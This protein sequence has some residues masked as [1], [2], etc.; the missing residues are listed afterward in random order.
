M[1][2]SDL[3]PHTQA[4]LISA[5]ND[6]APVTGLTHQHYRYPARF[7][8]TFV[9]AAI[10][11]FTDPGDVVLDP[12]MGGG[13]T[14]VEAL[15]S[16]RRA[17]G[18]DVSQLAT[19]VAE[20]KTLLLSP[21]D[22]RQIRQWLLRASNCV[23]MRR[24]SEEH[25][26]GLESYRRNLETAKHWRLHKAITLCLGEVQTL[27]TL[28]QQKFGRCVILR[29]AQWA[30][31]GRAAI[32]TV[33]EFRNAVSSFGTAM[34]DGA[35]Q[36]R[37]HTK[38]FQ[39]FSPRALFLNCSAAQLREHPRLRVLSRPKLVLT[40][41]PYPGIHVLYHRWQVDG[42]KETPAP[43]WIANKLDG[44]GA[45]FYTMGDRR[46]PNQTT[47]FSNLD[48]SFGSVASLCDENTI[49]VHV[50]SFSNCRTQLPRFL[51]TAER[52]GL[53]E[54]RL[55]LAK[56][57]DGR[58]WRKVPNRRWHAHQKGSTSASR[59]LVL[60]HRLRSRPEKAI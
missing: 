10:A 51:E 44:A 22:V 49:F 46:Q 23:N 31:D 27:E 52:H 40:S 28:K 25:G 37:I 3:D 55:P 41:P 30:L 58:L 34:L 47:Y 2:W 5:A 53:V 21:N 38:N 13:T 43:F 20:A 7:S 32:P 39:G 11:A 18:A 19:F 1:L 54:L 57:R 33:T 36:F 35:E 4:Y 14:L 16:G 26:L 60:F 8:P 24:V 9:R 59:E 6:D 12:F 17:V 42:R 50:V 45:S 56:S 29:V 15:A 48:A